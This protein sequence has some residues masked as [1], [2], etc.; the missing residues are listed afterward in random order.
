MGGYEQNFESNSI[1]LSVVNSN[2][3]SSKLLN[4]S[5]MKQYEGM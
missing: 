2:G 3:D 1:W 5:D 4:T